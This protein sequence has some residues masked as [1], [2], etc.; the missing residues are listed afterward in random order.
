MY[1]LYWFGAK[2]EFMC[3][4]CCVTSVWRDAVNSTTEDFSKLK[5]KIVSQPQHC[6]YCKT[7]LEDGQDVDIQIV[8]GTPEYLRGLGFVLPPDVGGR[9]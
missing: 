4:K 5:A 3:T 9:S 6:Q 8:P 2:V 1:H 7:E